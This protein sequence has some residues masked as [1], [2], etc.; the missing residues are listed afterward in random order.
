MGS[1]L[2][3]NMGKAPRL[4]ALG[5]LSSLR[6]RLAPNP[7]VWTQEV[8]ASA[9]SDGYCPARAGCQEL[10]GGA[11]VC[12]AQACQGEGDRAGQ[13]GFWDPRVP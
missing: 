13:T 5:R 3:G 12:L 11:G 8:A 9:T 1:W 4:A 10:S 6:K 7:H 2:K